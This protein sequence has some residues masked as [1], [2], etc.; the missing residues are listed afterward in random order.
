[1]DFTNAYNTTVIATKSRSSWKAL[2]IFTP[3]K[4]FFLWKEKNTNLNILAFR[5]LSLKVN[6]CKTLLKID[7]LYLFKHFL[8]RA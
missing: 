7:P 1:M 6:H 3:V 8:S 5:N 2:K 4:M